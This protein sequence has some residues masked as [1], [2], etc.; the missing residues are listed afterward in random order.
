MQ[1]GQQQRADEVKFVLDVTF[2]SLEIKVSRNA[3]LQVVASYAE[4][5]NYALDS[6]DEVD[7]SQQQRQMSHACCRCE[8]ELH[9]PPEAMMH[10]S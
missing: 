7:R 2:D 9:C 8:K 10:P 5:L 3:K 1:F 6:F 4:V